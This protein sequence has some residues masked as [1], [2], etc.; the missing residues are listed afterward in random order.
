MVESKTGDDSEPYYADFTKKD[1]SLPKPVVDLIYW[2][3]AKMSGAALGAGIVLYVL[4]SFRG[5]TYLSLTSLL[6]LTH[7]LISL[8]MTL[9]ARWQGKSTPQGKPLQVDPE[10]AKKAVEHVNRAIVWYSELLRGEDVMTAGKVVGVLFVTWT[11]GSWF[12][13]PTLLML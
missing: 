13:G 1:S 12:D 4:T 6:L 8:A 11:L 3:D 5:Y 10:L 7:L 9:V 2:K